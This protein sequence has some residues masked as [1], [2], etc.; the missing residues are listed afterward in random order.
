M[1]RLAFFVGILAIV[2]LVIA[3]PAYRL[4]LLPLIPALLGAAIGFLLFVVTFIVGAIGLLAGG[5][6]AFARSRAAVGVIALSLVITIVAG[7][8]ISR[9]RGA[10][11]IHDVTTDLNDPPVFKDAVPLR[12]ASGAVNP[13]EYQR[14][15]TIM[16]NK[17]NVPD[18][19]RSAY[20]D[21]QPL[22][23]RQPPARTVQL[24]QQAAKDMGWDILA[25]VPSEGR[26]EATDTTWYFGFK[27]DVAVRVQPDST[28]SRVDVRSESRVGGGDTGTNARRVRA[29]LARLHDLAGK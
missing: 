29:Y 23:L 22:V 15:Q 5:R 4:R 8:W 13:V 12:S 28:G 18:A 6:Q 11:P 10:P 1:A 16:G 20:P 7:F 24:A 19:Q 25:V 17:L 3:G 26:V 14:I 2:L 27:D 9:G 21:I